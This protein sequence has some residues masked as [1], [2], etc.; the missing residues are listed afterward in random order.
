MNIGPLYVAEGATF[1]P[2]ARY[3]TT[4]V[5]SLTGKGTV[6]LPVTLTGGYWPFRYDSNALCSFEGSIS[7]Q[8]MLQINGPIDLASMNNSFTGSFS[9]Y[10]IN[11]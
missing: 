4:V 9:I 6:M 1:K 10:N 5:S 3:R 8:I 11:I 2:Y 7:G